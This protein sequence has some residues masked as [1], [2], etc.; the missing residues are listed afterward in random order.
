MLKYRKVEIVGESSCLFKKFQV[1]ILLQFNGH[2]FYVIFPLED[3]LSPASKFRERLRNLLKRN[4]ELK[5]RCR[6]KLIFEKCFSF[7]TCIQIEDGKN[8]TNF[9]LCAFCCVDFV[10]GIFSEI[11]KFSREIS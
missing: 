11:V 5:R 7:L 2:S 4:T 1:R 10:I 3:R 9:E 6:C 8:G